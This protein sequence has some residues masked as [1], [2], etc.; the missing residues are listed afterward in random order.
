[1]NE[2]KTEKEFNKECKYF[3]IERLYTSGYIRMQHPNPNKQMLEPIIEIRASDIRDIKINAVMSDIN[4]YIY[5]Y[6]VVIETSNNKIYNKCYPDLDM[7]FRFER[8]LRYCILDLTCRNES[9]VKY[10][11]EEATNVIKNQTKE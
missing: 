4:D 7:A 3:G 11:I 10:G 2:I 9:L 5:C 8:C 6:V 1:M